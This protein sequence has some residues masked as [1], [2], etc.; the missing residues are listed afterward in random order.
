M[1]SKKKKIEQVSM[2]WIISNRY[3]Y[4]MTARKMYRVAVVG[5]AS[6]QTIVVRKR[7]ISL[8]LINLAGNRHCK[9][10]WIRRSQTYSAN[11]ITKRVTESN[12]SPG[13]LSY[14]LQLSFLSFSSFIF[15]LFWFHASTTF[16]RVAQ[17]MNTLQYCS[18]DKPHLS[19][20]SHHVY[21]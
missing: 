9:L 2:Q 8:K 20:Y 17:C 1:R 10:R 19:I 18:R 16:T 15:F 11:N 5:G 21:L 13:F 3:R 6:K 7:E 12:R 4:I 14:C